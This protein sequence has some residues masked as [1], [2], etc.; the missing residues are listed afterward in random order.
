[1]CPQ[2]GVCTSTRISVWDS[3]HLHLTIRTEEF[4]KVVLFPAGRIEILKNQGQSSEPLNAR[5]QP[6]SD[7]FSGF[8]VGKDFVNR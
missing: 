1:M 4:S 7:E 8:Q 3:K 5:R 2:V 6:Q